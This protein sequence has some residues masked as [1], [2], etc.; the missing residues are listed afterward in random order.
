MGISFI[1]W[2][3]IYNTTGA[4]PRSKGNKGSVYSRLVERVIWGGGTGREFG[5][6]LAI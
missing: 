6:F 4:V 2:L 3:V 1:R 5:A